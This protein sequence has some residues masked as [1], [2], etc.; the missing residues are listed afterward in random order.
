MAASIPVLR[1]L[2]R[3]TT[4][5]TGNYIKTDEA[6]TGNGSGNGGRKK[7]GTCDSTGTKIACEELEM[8]PQIDG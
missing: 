5:S 4:S 2:I 1:V 8:A 7:M 3:N 6:T